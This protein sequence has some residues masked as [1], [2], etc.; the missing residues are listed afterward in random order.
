MY[1]SVTALDI[2]LMFCLFMI[3]LAILQFLIITKFNRS[4]H[5]NNHIHVHPPQAFPSSDT[6]I[7]ENSK[8]VDVTNATNSPF[9][10]KNIQE[11][12]SK[13]GNE[14]NLDHMTSF[15][16]LAK[17]IHVYSKSILT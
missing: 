4:N 12:S 5:K 6:L 16:D 2:W 14:N 13:S 7:K 9:E 15:D 17:V 11:N 3:F 8:P 1:N 10:N